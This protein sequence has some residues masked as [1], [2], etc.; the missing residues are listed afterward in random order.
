MTAIDAAAALAVAD[1]AEEKADAVAAQVAGPEPGSAAGLGLPLTS[2]SGSLPAPDA[3]TSTTEIVNLPAGTSVQVVVDV[4]TGFADSSDLTVA[5]AGI[6]VSPSAWQD[7]PVDLATSGTYVT[8]PI[9]SGEALMLT[10]RGMITASLAASAPTIGS[11]RVTVHHSPVRQGSDGIINVQEWGVLPEN[12]SDTNT[13]NLYTLRD[14]CRARPKTL[15]HILFPPSEDVYWINRSDW[16]RGIRKYRLSGY[17]A[18]IGSDDGTF[19]KQGWHVY[20]CVTNAGMFYDY[21]GLIG[22]ESTSGHPPEYV[23]MGHL[24]NTAARGQCDIVLSSGG[25]FQ[26]GDYVLV[27]GLMQQDDGAPPNPRYFEYNQVRSVDGLT[28]T[29]ETPLRHTYRDDWPEWTADTYWFNHGRAR[30]LNLNRPDFNICEQAIIEGI[31]FYPRVPYAGATKDMGY[32]RVAGCL[33]VTVRDC[34][35]EKLVI[36]ESR[37]AFVDNCAVTHYNE[38]DKIVSQLEYKNSQLAYLHQGYGVEQLTLLGCEITNFGRGVAIQNTHSY[39]YARRLRITD[40]S[41][42]NGA[43]VGVDFVMFDIGDTVGKDVATIEGNVFHVKPGKQLSANSPLRWNGSRWLQEFELASQTD[44]GSK[45]TSV[46][47]NDSGLTILQQLHEGD[48]FIY[49]DQD[50][51]DV[52]RITKIYQGSQYDGSARKIRLDVDTNAIFMNAAYSRIAIPTIRTLSIRNNTSV[53]TETNEA[54][55]PEDSYFSINSTENTSFAWLD[56]AN[57]PS[58]WLFGFITEIVFDVIRPYT[59]SGTI[60]DYLFRLYTHTQNQGLVFS[61][62]SRGTLIKRLDTLTGEPTFEI[63][64][65]PRDMADASSTDDFERPLIKVRV[66]SVPPRPFR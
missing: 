12:D 8:A 39:S 6:A 29:V 60:P 16:L 44:D 30:V 41:F 31:H 28:L 64:M 33:N 2:T 66:K 22:D 45:T 9:G 18:K 23:D 7:A 17:G 46:E 42:L 21:D 5:L 48:R 49:S 38:Q 61:T 3:E 62:A 63:R 24:I 43:D 10:R 57:S 65:E 55:G 11:A 20:T 51:N 37:N 52:G 54:R 36:N 35:I 13:A 56:G 40:C 25:S 15:H 58:L 26:A 47:L 14:W 34:R 27:Y 32:L 53:T 1:A 4:V 50:T 59:G 19:Y